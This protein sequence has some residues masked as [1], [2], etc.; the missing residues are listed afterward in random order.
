M[1][2]DFHMQVVLLGQDT[3][4]KEYVLKKRGQAL[5]TIILFWLRHQQKLDLHLRLEHVAGNTTG[6]AWIRGVVEDQGEANIVGQ[7]KIGPRAINSDSFLRINVLTLGPTAKAE[8][9]PQLEIL[10]NEVKASHAATVGRFGDDE[11]FYLASRGLK[12][13]QAKR[14]LIAGF[15]QP[16]L[17]RI[18]NTR[19]R[20][21]AARA[22]IGDVEIG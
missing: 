5:D 18:K 17:Q 9:T 22:I 16:V 3:M 2:V 7:I 1:W 6:L 11:M 8:V 21:T 20:L 19:V 4:R 14:L 13:D 15:F 10:T 12:E